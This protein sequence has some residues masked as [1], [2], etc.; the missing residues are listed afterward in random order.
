M[1]VP[2]LYAPV[3]MGCIYERF[4][5]SVTSEEPDVPQDPFQSYDSVIQAGQTVL[6]LQDDNGILDKMIQ[7]LD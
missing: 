4:A 7:A 5:V 1:Q 6:Q 3:W 2:V